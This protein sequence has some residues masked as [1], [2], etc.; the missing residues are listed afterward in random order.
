MKGL[1]IAF[2]IWSFFLQAAYVVFPE[3]HQ[4]LYVDFTIS[5]YMLLF[6]F[7][8]NLWFE[9]NRYVSLV[10]MVSFPTFI[11][12]CYLLLHVLLSHPF[13][14]VSTSVI[15]VAWA[16]IILLM[17]PGLIQRRWKT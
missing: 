10:Y 17:N 15:S 2:G 8:L 6:S 5:V 12:R 3:V 13:D 7:M 16:F 14:W 9:D 11:F 1:I 4:P